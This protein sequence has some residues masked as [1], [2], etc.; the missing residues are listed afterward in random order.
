[1]QDDEGRIHFKRRK[2]SADWNAMAWTTLLGR[3]RDSTRSGFKICTPGLPGRCLADP[4][5]ILYVAVP[6]GLR[7]RILAEGYRPSRRWRLPKICVAL[8]EWTGTD[9][10]C[11]IC[12]VDEIVEVND[13]LRD[14]SDLWCTIVSWN[15]DRDYGVTE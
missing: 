12:E 3:A 1:M 13:T 11:K 6:S 2:S 9:P 5:N 4:S 14:W 10:F 7:D 15:T 8:E